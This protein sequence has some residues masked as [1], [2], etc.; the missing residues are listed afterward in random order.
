[1]DI[2]AVNAAIGLGWRPVLPLGARYRWPANEFCSG[3]WEVCFVHEGAWAARLLDKGWWTASPFGF[4]DYRVGIEVL[5]LPTGWEGV[6][7]CSDR[8][9]LH[10]DTMEAWRATNRD[11]V[12]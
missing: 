10:A 3:V 9:K 12:G 4:H 7:V 11:A 1:M 8:R 5:T 6:E 2:A